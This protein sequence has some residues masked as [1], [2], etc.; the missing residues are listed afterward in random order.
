MGKLNKHTTSLSLS[1]SHSLC[2]CL[3]LCVSLSL[4]LPLSLCLTLS[5]SAS[6]SVS[7]SCLTLSLCLT[8]SVSA[9][10]SLCLTLSLS[11]S[12]LLCVTC[13]DMAVMAGNSG[14]TCYSKYGAMSIKSKFCHEMALRIILHSLDLRANCYQ[15]YIEPLLSVSADFYIRV[16][17]RV[18]TGQAKVKSS[19]RYDPLLLAG[20]E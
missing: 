4:S 20:G 7:L 11:L 5:V 18:F 6:L 16:F 12:G 1:V 13:T 15:R 19:A 14:E 9:S 2:L 3:S 17:V 8:L 10:L